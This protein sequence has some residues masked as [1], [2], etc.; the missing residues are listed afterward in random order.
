SCVLG[1]SPA[2]WE[3]VLAANG[4]LYAARSTSRG[5][6]LVYALN[7]NGNFANGV[8]VVNET[9]GEGTNPT[10]CAKGNCDQS[11][12]EYPVDSATSTT[13]PLLPDNQPHTLPNPPRPPA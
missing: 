3:D 8:V 13:P 11:N 10:Q 4:V 6:A 1:P 12:K 2:E 7:P 9:I 5:E